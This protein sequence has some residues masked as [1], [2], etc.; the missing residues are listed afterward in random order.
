VKA[1]KAAVWYGGK[2]VRIEDV[3]DPKINIEEILIR[4]KSVGICGSEA[5]AFQGKSKR[6]VP[7]LIMGHEFA[8]VVA[9]VGTGVRDFQ[10]GDRVV[11]EPL[12]SCGTCE[13]CSSG[14]SNICVELKVIG[15]HIPGA[16]AEYVAVP[17]KKCHKLADSVSFDEAALVEPL[18][19][20][21]HAVAITPAELGDNLLVI[22]S[23]VVGLM[24]LQIAKLRVGG[25]V[26]VSDLIDYKLEIAKTLGADTVVDTGKEDLIS[27]IGELTKGNGVDAVIEAVGVQQTLQQAL[28]VVKKGGDI[29]VAGLLERM[30]QLD[31]MRVVAN[32]ITIRGDYSYTTTEFKTALNFLA[33]GT[34]HV[35]PLI[36]HAFSLGEMG[37]AVD[38]LAEGKEKH[39]KIILRP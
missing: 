12:I 35:K 2:D 20:G 38:I 11:V 13:P 14:R 39:V 17:A 33:N 7:P 21:T 23:G 10:N 29:T 22:G 37:R 30:V 25:K 15:L 4:V 34:V 31:I 3:P 18:S 24:V 36:T 27:R 5:Q 28:T 16:F 32:E 6:R 9:D 1:M 8:G 26:F 19:V